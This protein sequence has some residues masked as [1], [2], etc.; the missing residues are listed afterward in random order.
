MCDNKAKIVLKG[1]TD[2]PL[3][4]CIN[5]LFFFH[6]SICRSSQC[7]L[8]CS[9]ALLQSLCIHVNW[10]KSDAYHCIETNYMPHIYRSSQWFGIEVSILCVISFSAFVVFFCC[11]VAV[12]YCIVSVALHSNHFVALNWAIENIELWTRQI[13]WSFEI[14]CW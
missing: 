2:L 10:K 12:G 4:Y 9:I 1:S 7:V 8:C 5:R 11:C 3:L 14:L 13:A 6:S